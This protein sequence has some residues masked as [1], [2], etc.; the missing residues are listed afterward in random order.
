MKKLI[1]ILLLLPVYLSAQSLKYAIF[2]NV[3][4]TS[5]AVIIDPGALFTGI[6]VPDDINSDAITFSVS[7]DGTNYYSLF[8]HSNVISGDVWVDS[9]GVYT[10]IPADTTDVYFSTLPEEVFK[11]VRRIKIILDAASS[12]NQDT[13]EVVYQSKSRF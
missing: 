10:L 9:T 2:G 5:N 8:S 1:F 6:I 7:R 13:V 11:N 3:A 12:A 4:T